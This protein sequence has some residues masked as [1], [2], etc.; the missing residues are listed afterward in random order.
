MYNLYL[1]VILTIFTLMILS[2]S[3]LSERLKSNNSL[4]LLIAL[5][6]ILFA[7]NDIHIGFLMLAILFTVLLSVKKNDLSFE[8]I[9]NS[10]GF[11][12]DIFDFTNPFAGLTSNL[13]LD[14]PNTDITSEADSEFDDNVSDIDPNDYITEMDT[15][16]NNDI[17]NLFDNYLQENN[18]PTPPTQASENEHITS[19]QLA[20]MFEHLE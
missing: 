15:S 19:Q 7:Y 18:E 9:I 17:D 6:V 4:Q 10:F 20:K 1:I 2:N 14:S 5:L 13:N 11:N 12:A 8:K 3:T 16:V